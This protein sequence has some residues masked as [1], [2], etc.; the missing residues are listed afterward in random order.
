MIWYRKEIGGDGIISCDFPRETSSFL[1][2]ARGRRTAKISYDRWFKGLKELWQ[3]ELRR[4]EIALE[5]AQKRV[6]A[7]GARVKR[8]KSELE[9][10]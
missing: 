5:S 3:D 4:A 2:D 8:A 10:L 9:A 1:V 7:E 6:A